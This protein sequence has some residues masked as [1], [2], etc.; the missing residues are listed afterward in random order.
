MYLLSGAEESVTGLDEPPE[1][2]QCHSDPSCE[3]LKTLSG[4]LGWNFTSHTKTPQEERTKLVKTETSTNKKHALSSLGQ[5]KTTKWCLMFGETFQ[6][7]AVRFSGNYPK[8][9]DFQE[10]KFCLQLALNRPYLG[11]R[12]SSGSVVPFNKDPSV[13]WPPLWK[14]CPQMLASDENKFLYP[15]SQRPPLYK[16]C[17][18]ILLALLAAGMV[19]TAG[20]HYTTQADER[21]D[22]AGNGQSYIPSAEW[23]LSTVT[24]NFSCLMSHTHIAPSRPPVA[25]MWGCVGCLSRQWR[26]TRSPVLWRKSGSLLVVI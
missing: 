9:L 13:Q 15:S 26:G 7:D 14:R 1:L 17:C 20:D 24:G 16:D 6:I 19:S 2:F 21:Q 22:T 12:V 5:R 23:A 4:W 25:T 18:L 11:K 8:Q 3:Q 10:K